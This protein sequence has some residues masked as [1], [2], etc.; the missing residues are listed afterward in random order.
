M[1]L[2]VLEMYGLENL[3]LI[4]PPQI[5][6]NELP[7]QLGVRSGLSAAGY[8]HLFE[9]IIF[10]LWYHKWCLLGRGACGY[11]SFHVR[12][13]VLF[14]SFF[15]ILFLNIP[16]LG[17]SSIGIVWCEFCKGSSECICV[18]VVLLCAR[19]SGLHR[20]VQGSL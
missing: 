14:F 6:R 10:G 2:R 5:K 12:K 18:L 11:Q 13:P 3:P 17:A 19:L 20:P 15:F 16:E 9:C 7:A 8:S 4:G 1:S